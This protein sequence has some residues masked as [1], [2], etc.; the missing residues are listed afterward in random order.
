MVYLR[1]SMRLPVR[2]TWSS[3]AMRIGFRLAMGL[4]YTAGSLSRRHKNN[5]VAGP[6][7]MGRLFLSHTRKTFLDRPDL[8]LRILFLPFFEVDDFGFGVLYKTL[9][10][11]LLVY[12]FEKT[13]QVDQFL[14]QLFLLVAAV[15][16]LLRND[17]I[18]ILTGDDRKSPRDGVGSEIDAFSI[19][20]AGKNRLQTAEDGF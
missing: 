19:D 14:L 10:P 5:S 1:R 4:L 13:L 15:Q 16:H 9:V 18:L 17:I 12:G 20:L 7:Q 3:P 2:L 8:Y 11:Q 6:E